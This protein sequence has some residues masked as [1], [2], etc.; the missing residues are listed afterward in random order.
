MGQAPILAVL[1]N[2]SSTNYLRNLKSDMTS[3][4]WGS[5]FDAHSQK[6][7]TFLRRLYVQSTGFND[8]NDVAN[9]SNVFD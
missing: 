1:D 9:H 4:R 2:N 6:K 7:E 3:A 5:N 8:D